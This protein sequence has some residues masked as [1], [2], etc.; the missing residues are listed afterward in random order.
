MRNVTFLM[1]I[2]TMLLNTL[3][4]SGQ[5]GKV[6]KTIPTPAENAT[7]LTFDGKNLWLTDRKTD[8]LYCIN[9]DDGSIV[10]TL[11]TPAYWPAGLAWD[12][13][14]LWNA[15]IKGGIPLSENYQGKAYKIDP[16]TG[17]ILQ[18]VST[19]GNN[20]RG[21]S[22]D[23]QYLWCIDDGA[24]EIVLF[25]AADGTT[26]RSIKSPTTRPQ[27]LTFDGDYLW[28]SD[29]VANEIYMVEPVTGTVIITFPAPGPFIRDLAYD[30]KT[31]WAVD[32][33]T[34]SIYQLTIRDD[35][36][37]QL[38]NKKELKLTFTHLTTNFGP[39]EVKTLDVHIAIPRDR[40]NQ[41]IIASPEYNIDYTD[42]VTDAWGQKTAHW[43]RE[44]IPAGENFEASM[45]VMATTYDINYFIFP[46][47]VG[48]PDQIPMDIRKSYLA[49]NEKY[50]ITHPVIV[51]AVDEALDGEKNMYWKARKLYNYIQAHMYYEMV[52]GWNTAPAVLARGNGSCS[53][54]SFVYIAM[55]RAAGI[56]ARYVGAVSVRSEISA[57]DDV[58]HRWVEI[59]LPQYGWIPVDPSGGD[60]DSP[61]HQAKYF[62]HLRGKYIIT[63]QSGGGSETM[64]WTYNANEFI[65]TDPKTFV[66]SEHIGDWDVI[67]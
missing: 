9:P 10:N 39:G 30:G 67:K 6:L 4:V 42:I 17:T 2:V 28:V 7:G 61:A 55:C 19:P 64:E 5:T 44:N 56:P 52:G 45:T 31:L 40:V 49:D 57:Y 43:Y 54:Y 37:Y 62:G 51:N 18:T 34:D 26:I 36:K 24:D 27:G 25:N 29:N 13:I 15:D 46:E 41:T 66:V 22:S 47:K 3:A 50:N 8:L 23:G 21:L 60:S 38:S 32:S 65:T 12:G 59:Y 33:Q 58:F 48:T 1:V 20:P 35:K 53:E 16:I 63:T 11:Q 14:Y